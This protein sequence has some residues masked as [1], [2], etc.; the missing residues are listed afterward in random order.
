MQTLQQRMLAVRK[1]AKLSQEEFALKVGT[2][3]SI[4]SQMEI[5][6]IKPSYEVLITTAKEFGVDY[7]YLLEGDV[8]DGES[9]TMVMEAPSAGYN[10][11]DNV[12]ALQREIYFL[13]KEVAMLS[14][15]VQ[16]Q[17]ELIDAYKKLLKED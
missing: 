8:Q 12:K 15:Q 13:R 10:S 14:T 4:I 7:K 17:D 6:K 3:R 9:A 1:R 2:S 16:R 5:G 11:N